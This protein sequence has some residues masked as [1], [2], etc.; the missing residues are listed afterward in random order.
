MVPLLTIEG[1]VPVQMISVERLRPHPRNGE[2]FGPLDAET[3]EALKADIAARGIQTPLIV[4]PDFTILAG[5]H[6]WEL[7][8]E[9][10]LTELPVIVRDLPE[11]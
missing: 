1:V 9:L 4:L 8:R 10:G 6:R 5:H 3:R 11:D 2:Y 7:A